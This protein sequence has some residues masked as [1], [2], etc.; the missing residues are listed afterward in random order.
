MKSA[1]SSGGNPLDHLQTEMDAC[2]LN[3]KLETHENED[4][5]VHDHLIKDGDEAEDDE[6]NKD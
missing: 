1:L 5:I 6:E 3:R 2:L 4:D